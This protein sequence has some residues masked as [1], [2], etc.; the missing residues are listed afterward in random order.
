MSAPLEMPIAS[1]YDRENRCY[2]K[3]WR[4]PFAMLAPH[5]E[6]AKKNHGGQDLMR[7]YH[8]YGISACEACAIM[9][10]RPWKPMRHQEAADALREHVKRYN[11]KV[12]AT[13]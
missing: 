5:N 6:Q 4:V 12:E 3:S 11:A 2:T 10:D 9:E 13:A 8:R 7:L 1:L